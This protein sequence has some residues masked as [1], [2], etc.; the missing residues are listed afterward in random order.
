M[1]YKVNRNDVVP[2]ESETGRTWRCFRRD[3]PYGIGLGVASFD[4]LPD[5]VD[6]E[7]RCEAH[8]VPEVHYVLTGSGVLY[9]EGETIELRE[10]DAV[11]T[12]AGR[13]HTIWSVG[14][15]PVVTVY[16][17]ISARALAEG[18]GSPT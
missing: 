12:P 11:I 18:A 8:D 4:P 14:R 16:S 17:A 13:R 9:E 15:E 3:G 6:P 7:S 1:S 2:E 5:G 10:G